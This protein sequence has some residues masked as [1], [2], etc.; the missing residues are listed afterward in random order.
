MK[1][2]RAVRL[3]IE[4]RQ[5]QSERFGSMPRNNDP[6]LWIVL[7]MEELG[8]ALREL[9]LDIAGTDLAIGLF[10][11]ELIELSEKARRIIDLND[12]EERA[13]TVPS[14]RYYLEMI[15]VAALAVAALEDTTEVNHGDP[16][17]IHPLD[18]DSRGDGQG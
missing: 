12:F 6:L 11:G 1:Q 14:P 7:I 16:D 8:E 4:E 5:R 15:Q 9:E 10:V 2:V 3:V 13:K 18:S 17:K